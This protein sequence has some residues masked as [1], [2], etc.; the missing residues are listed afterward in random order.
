MKVENVWNVC[1]A[2]MQKGKKKIQTMRALLKF[3]L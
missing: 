3:T 2:Q 1:Q